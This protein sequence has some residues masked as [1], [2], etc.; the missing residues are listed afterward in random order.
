MPAEKL[1]KQVLLIR[2]DANG[3]VKSLRDQEVLYSILSH[4]LLLVFEKW[5]ND[6]INIVSDSLYVVGIV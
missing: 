6:P 4:V 1:L 2:T 3:S 5:P